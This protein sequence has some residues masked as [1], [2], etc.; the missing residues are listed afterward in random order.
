M[1]LLKFLG[2]GK[3]EPDGRG[4]SAAVRAISEQLS[5]LPPEQARYCAAFAYLLARVAHA[6]LATEACEQGAIEE[7]LGRIE[8]LP[9]ELIRLL[10]ETA[11]A[12]ATEEGGTQN[13]LVSREFKAIASRDE[14]TRLL[15]CLYAVAAAD[16]LVSNLEDIEI[17]KIAAELGL[18][19]TDV[20]ALRSE[21]E[22]KLGV[23]RPLSGER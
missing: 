8:S 21:W 2:M 14:C 3:D 23:F 4:E 10:A 22:D 11:V 5:A 9:A 17:F 12:Q 15:R 13:Y 7:R 16:D 6:D 19:R 1:S 20:I 18:A